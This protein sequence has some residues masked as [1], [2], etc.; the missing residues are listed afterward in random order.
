[1]SASVILPS[2]AKIGRWLMRNAII[3]NLLKS[4]ILQL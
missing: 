1:M 3:R 2:V 4:P